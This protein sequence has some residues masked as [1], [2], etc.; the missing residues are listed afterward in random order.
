M[1]E[2]FHE[3]SRGF[4]SISKIAD[5]QDPSKGEF[6]QWKDLP[7]IS[8]F[9][10]ATDAILKSARDHGVDSIKDLPLDVVKI[11]I[12]TDFV[13]KT[14]IKFVQKIID[15]TET[16]IEESPNNLEMTPENRRKLSIA[17]ASATEDQSILP[18]FYDAC[19]KVRTHQS[20][21]AARLTNQML[22]KDLQKT[23]KAFI[24]FEDNQGLKLK[25]DA[26]DGIWKIQYRKQNNSNCASLSQPL[27]D[28]LNALTS[29]DKDRACGGILESCVGM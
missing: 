1:L 23:V 5:V 16:P 14:C 22:L 17:L 6:G 26:C 15:G 11:A 27:Q 12:M 9:Y 3:A 24:D 2:K 4:A 19:I 18:A 10:Q 21:N 25:K 28:I 29:S 7:P 8:D 20:G 13:F